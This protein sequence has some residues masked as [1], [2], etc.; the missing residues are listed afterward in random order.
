M[1]R[2]KL[3][4]VGFGDDL[5]GSFGRA[6]FEFLSDPLNECFESCVTMKSIPIFCKLSNFPWKLEPKSVRKLIRS[7][8]NPS[9]QKLTNYMQSL[10]LPME[11][12]FTL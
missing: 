1:T 8:L 6:P 2:L 12:S 10:N 4:L 3:N 5:K 11:S 9:P 7:S